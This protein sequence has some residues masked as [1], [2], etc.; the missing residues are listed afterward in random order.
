MITYKL[1]LRMGHYHIA[2]ESE[3]R[4]KYRQTRKKKSIRKMRCADAIQFLANAYGVHLK[5]KQSTQ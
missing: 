1:V 2:I 4:T 3:H 5:N